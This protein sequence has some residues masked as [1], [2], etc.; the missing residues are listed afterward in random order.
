MDP[1]LAEI[2]ARNLPAIR[3][4]L[5]KLEQA[6]QACAHGDSTASREA[7]AEAAHQLAGSLGS[8]GVARGS[9]LARKLER[10]F[11][12]GALAGDSGEL[13]RLVVE[14]RALVEERG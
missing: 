7:A 2:W 12:P 11:E 8:F 4:R 14:L 6:A 5:G 1:V 13:S 9:E 10:R 3:E